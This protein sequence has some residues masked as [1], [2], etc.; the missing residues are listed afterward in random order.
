MAM[1]CL[2]CGAENPEGRTFCGDCGSPFDAVEGM[3]AKWQKRLAG[4]TAILI[5]LISVLLIVIGWGFLRASNDLDYYYGSDISHVAHSFYDLAWL[6]GLLGIAGF[7]IAGFAYLLAL[8]LPKKERV[9]SPASE[10]S[11][12]EEMEGV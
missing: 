3:S 10:E 6:F 11:I 9:V 8:P 12:G 7:F 1:K 5:A 4:R 2:V